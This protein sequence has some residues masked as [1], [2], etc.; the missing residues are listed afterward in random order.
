MKLQWRIVRSPRNDAL[1]GVAIALMAGFFLN[2]TLSTQATSVEEK[3]TP[4]A[5]HANMLAI[6]LTLNRNQPPKLERATRLESGRVTLTTPGDNTLLLL[7]ANGKTLYAQS[8]GADFMI[9]SE[10]PVMLDSLPLIFVVPYTNQVRRVRLLTPNG[11]AE[12]A[13]E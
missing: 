9:A 13:I 1:I 10:P 6:D 3:S 11:P 8:F 12:L 2:L 4:F 7:D 5:T